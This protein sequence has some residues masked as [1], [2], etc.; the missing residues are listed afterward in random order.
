MGGLAKRWLDSVAVAIK[1]N[2]LRMYLNS[3]R[4]LARHF[5]GLTVRSVS[6]R[7]IEQWAAQR[8]GGCSARTYNADLEVLRRIL[9]YACKHGLLLEN[10][11]REISRRKLSKEK[12]VIPTKEQFRKVLEAM[13]KNNGKDSADLVEF[14]AY[15]GCRLGEVVG[16]S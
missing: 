14:L 10:P 7:H 5:G 9:D 6:L 11:A 2:T 13:R 1:P 3:V 16:D 8:S 12:L 15:S 4:M